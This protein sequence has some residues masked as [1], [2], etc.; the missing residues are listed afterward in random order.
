MLE[1][2]NRVREGKKRRERNKDKYKR[3]YSRR[4]IKTQAESH[5]QTEE[6]GYFLQTK[7]AYLNKPRTDLR[8]TCEIYTRAP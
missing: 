6:P 5:R 4:W 1:E 3:D 2:N 8:E 7:R